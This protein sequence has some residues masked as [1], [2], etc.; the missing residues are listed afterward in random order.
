MF[1]LLK[2]LKALEGD[3]EGVWVAKLGWVVHDIDAEQVY[4]RHVGGGLLKL[5]TVEMVCGTVMKI[6][7][8][9]VVV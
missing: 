6:I 9:Y 1:T 7:E 8:S 3:L 5:V 4:D 2:R